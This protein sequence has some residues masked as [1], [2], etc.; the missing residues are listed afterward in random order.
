MF[1]SYVGTGHFHY[2]GQ[3][4]VLRDFHWIR[5]GIADPARVRVRAAI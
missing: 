5:V 4:L 2:V 3:W 1:T